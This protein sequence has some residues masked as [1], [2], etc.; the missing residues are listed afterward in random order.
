MKIAL[1]VIAIWSSCLLG[2][3][4]ILSGISPELYGGTFQVS[5]IPY[6]A[7]TLASF[8]AAMSGLGMQ[9]P[10]LKYCRGVCVVHGLLLV[11]FAVVMVWW[12]GSDGVGMGWMFVI[13][14]GSV[15]ALIISIIAWFALNAAAIRRLR[16]Q[17]SSP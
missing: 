1:G 15:I 14:P 4:S 2:M 9:E 12:S 16:S 6:F 13:G 7:A 11:P 5:T 10:T 3:A 8:L 17:P